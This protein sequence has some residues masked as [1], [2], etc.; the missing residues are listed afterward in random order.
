MRLR[1]G[2]M[3]V[4]DHNLWRSHDILDPERCVAD[5][6]RMSGEFLWLCAENADA[7]SMYGRKLGLLAEK[8]GDPIFRY[9]AIRSDD[10]AK[11]LKPDEFKG[12]RTVTHVALGAPVMLISNKMYG[13]DTALLGLTNGA[14]GVVGGARRAAASAPPE[15]PEYVVVDFHGY[16]GEPIF[17]GNGREKWVPVPFI[18]AIGDAKKNASRIATPLIL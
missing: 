3:N 10:G 5:I 9:E 8:A 4:E 13:V 6:L 18:E 17:P 11:R 14:R 7:G 1:D 12:L 2:A 15:L 16:I